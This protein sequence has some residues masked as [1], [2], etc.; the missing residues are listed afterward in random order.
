MDQ[1]EMIAI[2]G[3]FLS[4]CVCDL[5]SFVNPPSILVSTIPVPE[6]SAVVPIQPS[7][8]AKQLNNDQMIEV[9]PMA[10]Y[11]CSDP[12]ISCH[13]VMVAEE[14]WKNLHSGRCLGD[15]HRTSHGDVLEDPSKADMPM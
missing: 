2:I 1:T 14:R 12:Q 11:N 4:F 6:K 8:P 7:D 10:P 9:D 5:E 3:F 13:P 15:P